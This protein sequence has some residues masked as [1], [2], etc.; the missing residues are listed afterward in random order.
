MEL[1]EK[2]GIEV[3]GI[4]IAGKITESLVQAC[5]TNPKIKLQK[6]DLDLILCSID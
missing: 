2:D 3:E 6:F 4:I 1:F 5:K